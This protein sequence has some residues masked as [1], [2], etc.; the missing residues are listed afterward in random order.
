VT[1]RSRVARIGAERLAAARNSCCHRELRD[2]SEQDGI[3]NPATEESGTRAALG[4]VVAR[5]APKEL[6]ANKERVC[7]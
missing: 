3:G 7:G 4:R 1:G 6:S 5:W 2:R